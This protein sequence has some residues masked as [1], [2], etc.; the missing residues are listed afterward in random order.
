MSECASAN[1]FFLSLS[2]LSLVSG[3]LSVH[4]TYS[5]NVQYGMKCLGIKA[6]GLN[7]GESRVKG[8]GMER[9][10]P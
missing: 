9:L 10:F 5:C 6:E 4:L 1:T 8:K 2:S 3:E 7:C